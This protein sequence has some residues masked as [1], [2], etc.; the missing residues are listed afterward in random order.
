[1]NLQELEQKYQELGQE[2]ERLKA[3]KQTKYPIYCRNKIWNDVI[4][5]NSLNEGVCVK[6]GSNTIV[7]QKGNFMY[8]H[9]DRSVWQQL[10]VCPETG[11]FDG[12]LVWC[13][14]NDD[15]HRRELRF[16]NVKYGHA[17]RHDGTSSCY[18]INHDN[19]EPYEGNYPD[20]AQKAFETLEIDYEEYN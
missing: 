13:W 17:Y 4:K 5:F 12:Q 18:Y 8:K 3:K 11:F 15:T 7:G 19:Y 20:W 6:Q 14:D 9:T 2:I 10:K 1:M 16:Y